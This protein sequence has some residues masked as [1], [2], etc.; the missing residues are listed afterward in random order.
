MIIQFEQGLVRIVQEPQ[1][2]LDTS[3]PLLTI[4]VSDYVTLG[5]LLCEEVGDLRL[6]PGDSMFPY[7]LQAYPEQLPTRISFAALAD[8]Q[9]LVD[10]DF[11][12]KPKA[13]RWIRWYDQLPDRAFG[14][15]FGKYMVG[16]CFAAEV[17][18]TRWLHCLLDDK[19]FAYPLATFP[20]DF[21]DIWIYED[22][23]SEEEDA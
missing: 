22:E 12:P 1:F 2:R 9:L 14:E 5:S 13:F 15:H 19:F 17:N 6:N 18:K 23:E 21:D 20:D 7:S 4:Q 8:T 3:S 16:H 11:T 10:Q